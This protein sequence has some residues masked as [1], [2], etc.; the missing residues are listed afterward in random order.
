MT[1][2]E[3]LDYLNDYGWSNTNFGLSRTFEL[4]EALGD[5]QKKLRF[6]HVAGS[7]GKGSTCAMLAAILRQAGYRTGLYISPFIQDFCERM[8]VNGVPVS[9]EELA[10]ITALIK[11]KAEQMAEHPTHFE[12]VT[13]IGMEYFKRHDCDIVVLEVGMGG[14]FDSTNVID[15]PEVAVITNI[16]LDHTEYLGDTVEKIA[17]TKGGIIKTGSDCVCYD[18]DPAATEVIRSI[19]AE[20]GVPLTLP[21]FQSIRELSATLD[22]Q[23]FLYKEKIHTLRLLGEH[24]QHNAAVVIEIVE[25]L[26]NK[27]FSIGNDA[28]DAGLRTVSWPARFEILTRQPLFILD[29]GHNPQCAEALTACLDEYLPGQKVT[30]LMGMLA[31]KDYRTVMDIVCPYALRI[32]CISPDN[33]RALT[34]A[35]LA[36]IAAEHGIEAKAYDSVADGVSAARAITDSPV[37]AFG[38]LYTAGEI[39]SE[40]GFVSGE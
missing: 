4:L 13:A 39:R 18:G 23:V 5:P 15:A 37:I 29:G 17:A 22:G 32:L 16:G 30:M 24:Q 25:R 11:D 28:V 8:Q 3:A 31:D 40:M 6:V 2:T 9:H 21:D 33:K 34:A 38:S 27:G 20:R 7:N 36:A 14:E 1:Y 26:R 12:M 19:C 35:G 10:D